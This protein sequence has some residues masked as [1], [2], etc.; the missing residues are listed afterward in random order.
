LAFADPDRPA[1]YKLFRNIGP[2]E[3]LNGIQ[4]LTEPFPKKTQTQKTKST[5][6]IEFKIPAK[7]PITDDVLLTEEIAD[8]PE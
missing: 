8:V 3:L 6:S 7:P 1:L 2:I 5:K 4:P